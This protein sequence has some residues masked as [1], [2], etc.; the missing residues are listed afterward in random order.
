M[1][2]KHT[3]ESRFFRI[4]PPQTPDFLNIRYE[5]HELFIKYSW[6]WKWQV[7]EI[8]G[9]SGIFMVLKGSFEPLYICIYSFYIFM[10]YT[11][12]LKRGYQKYEYIAKTS[13]YRKKNMN[14]S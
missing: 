2:K 11:H 7:I 1:T 13:T 10:P 4:F 8:I 6:S 12:R 9:L 3:R 14:I 5:I